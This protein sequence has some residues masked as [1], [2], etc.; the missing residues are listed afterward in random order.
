VAA[1]LAIAHFGRQPGFSLPRLLAFTLA[2]G[3]VSLFPL[4]IEFGSTRARFVL[5]DSVLVAAFFAMGAP[6]VGLAAA[7]GELLSC[8]VLRVPRLKMVFNTANRLGATTVAASV[9]YA[10]GGTS[11][12]NARS[13]LAAVA[14]AACFSAL[15]MAGVAMVLARVEHRRYRRIVLHSG[16][17]ALATTLAT[18][19]LGLI[20]VALFDRSPFAP[21][22]L[23]PPM[24]VV[25][26]NSRFAAAQ[27]DEQLRVERLYE[28]T[29]RTARLTTFADAV[30]S[31]ADES[32]RLLTGVAA[33][34][35][36]PDA[37]GRSIAVVVDDSSSRAQDEEGADALVGLV[38]DHGPVDI[39]V[40]QLPQE[41]RA[42]S[43]AAARVVLAH[44]PSD[45]PVPVTLAVF[46]GS[47]LG[48]SHQ[49][50]L[51]M[52]T[53]FAAQAS[54]T[55]GNA[56]LYAEVGEALDRQVDLNRQKSEF[57]AAVSHELRT[58]LTAML[59]ASQTMLRLGDRLPGEDRGKLL[60]GAVDA[61]TRLKRLIEE[62]LLVASAEHRAETIELSELEVGDLLAGMAGEMAPSVGGRLEVR[63]HPGAGAI[64]S[65]AGRLHRILVNLVDNANKY[66][67][68]GPIEVRAARRGADVVVAVTDH[69]PGISS[70]DRS[71]VFERFVQ[72]DQSATRRQGGTGLGLYL[73]R[74]LAEQLGGSLLLDDTPGGGCT[75]TL[76]VPGLSPARSA[77][78]ET[79]ATV[80]PVS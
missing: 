23:V 62:L 41:I 17:T 19:P 54:L 1:G 18:A 5:I 48:G 9:F 2:F 43:P 37:A 68:A 8:G 35:C 75:F 14:S 25:A 32:R 55:I 63:S 60:T 50:L 45:S 26:L 22:L 51:D 40:D 70:A 77:A 71:R 78:P 74:R 58:P 38:A 28:A 29:S 15:D 53:A 59:G 42:I 10:L 44:S 67:P 11:S 79:P 3:L 76:K 47:T 56:R 20:A 49:G 31:V 4:R 80:S 61:G 6:F 33:V 34:C 21:L 69:G 52:L 16:P 57:V 13:W 39:G 65:D 24:L 73:S 46:R 72:L 64:V 12:L 30:A 27:R 7:A 36:A 66:A